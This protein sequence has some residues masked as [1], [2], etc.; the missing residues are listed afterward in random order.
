MPEHLFHGITCPVC[1]ISGNKGAYRALVPLVVKDK[2]IEPH[3][4]AVCFDCYKAQWFDVYGEARGQT[5]DEYLE[6]KHRK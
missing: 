4:Y 3:T 5:Y 1:K 6:A 2:V